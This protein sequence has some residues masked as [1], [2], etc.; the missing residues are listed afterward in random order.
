MADENE[1][2]SWMSDVLKSDAAVLRL[3]EV[4]PSISYQSGGDGQREIRSFK[5]ETYKK[6]LDLALLKSRLN[7][8]VESNYFHDAE[9]IRSEF[10]AAE[11]AGKASRF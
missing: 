11:E 5:E 9:R 6:I 8:I 3:A 2:K 10:F 7:E 4:L 1:V